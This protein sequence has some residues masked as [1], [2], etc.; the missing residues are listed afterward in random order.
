MG[1]KQKRVRTLPP[2]TPYPRKVGEEVGEAGDGDEARHRLDITDA[3]KP[4]RPDNLVRLCMR[5]TA[6]I[7][8][9]LE[10]KHPSR[11]ESKS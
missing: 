8:V 3:V 4:D 10:L 1:G 5:E 9:L 11:S 6:N 2:Y 7:A